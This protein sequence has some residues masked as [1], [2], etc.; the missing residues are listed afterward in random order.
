MNEEPPHP[1]VHAEA[2]GRVADVREGCECARGS[3]AARELL[4]V[5]HAVHA[6]ISWAWPWREEYMY[7]SRGRVRS[8]QVRLRSGQ[9]RSGQVRSGRVRSGQV[10][11]GQVRSEVRSGQVT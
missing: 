10:R 6:S 2:N 7:C 1:I 5:A 4:D 11:S 3:E 9:V 8:G